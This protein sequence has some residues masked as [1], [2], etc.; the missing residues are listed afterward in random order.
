MNNSE[1]IE[2]H[3]FAYF[4]ELYAAEENGEAVEDR[5]E[6]ERAIPEKDESNEAC[7]AEITT[8]EILSAIRSGAAKKAPGSDGFPNEWYKKAFDVIH[9]ELNLVL[10]EAL[11]GEFPHEFAA[12]TIVLVRERGGDDT[13]HAYRPISLLNVDF[14]ILSRILKGRLEHVLRTH[15]FL[16][17]T[18]PK[19]SGGRNDR[20]KAERE[21]YIV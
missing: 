1:E 19:G 11:A 15:H 2:Q 18:F 5:F 14:K 12:G 9:R 21:A 17:D 3:L 10:N 16:S 13:A 6:C 20:E 8:A 4:R 7:V